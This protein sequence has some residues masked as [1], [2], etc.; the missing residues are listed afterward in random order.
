MNESAIEVKNVTKIFEH[1]H[2]SR[3][4]VSSCELSMSKLK[5]NTR[6]TKQ[7]HPILLYFFFKNKPKV[8]TKPDKKNGAVFF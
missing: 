2:I 6:Y 3:Q 1:I 7:T 4:K 5:K 8:H